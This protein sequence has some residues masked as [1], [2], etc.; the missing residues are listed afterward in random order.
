ML[1]SILLTALIAVVAAQN[2]TCVSG[3]AVHMIIARASLEAPG[4]G[5]IGQVAT[6]VAAQLP[7]SDMVSVVYPATIND[8]TTSEDMGVVA[9]TKLVTDY[10]SRCPSSK[11]VLMGYSQGAQVTADVLCGR[12]D[13]ATFTT[14]QAA[15][16]TI[17]DKVAAVVLMGDPSKTTTETF[18]QGTSTKNGI[19]PRQD[20]AGCG[21]VANRMVSYCNAGDTFCDSGNSLQVHLSYV[22][23]NG[24]SAVTFVLNQIKPGTAAAA[25]AAGGTS[26]NGTA[27]VAAKAKEGQATTL[28]MSEN[29]VW[30]I[31][32]GFTAFG[33]GV[34]IF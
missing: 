13:G 23:N 27:A 1:S 24:T 30:S 14:T 31:V 26:S 19:F 2:T 11:M 16:T 10:A 34:S 9:M 8:Y 28:R 3:D 25:S 15:P 7:G 17:T 5:V 29:R 20:I 21:A 12:S 18:L 22:Q 4:P 6:Q 33:L 32:A